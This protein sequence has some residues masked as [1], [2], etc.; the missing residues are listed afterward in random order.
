MLNQ[1]FTNNKGQEFQVLTNPDS[2]GI[3][4]VRYLATDTT[5]SA[6][7][8]SIKSKTLTNPILPATAGVGIR[9]KKPESDLEKKFFSRWATMLQR[10]YNTK[11][12][13]YQYYGARGVTVSEEFK[14][15]P[16]FWNWVKTQS[17]IHW[18]LDSDLSSIVH[19]EAKRYSKETLVFL[20]KPLNHKLVSLRKLLRHIKA[21]R[22]GETDKPPK[23]ISI[24][25]NKIQINIRRN[26]FNYSNSFAPDKL[27]SVLELL[28]QKNITE[29]VELSDSFELCPR[30]KELIECLKNS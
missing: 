11:D 8:A 12:T 15:F 3:C 22:S 26:G 5:T 20:P 23:G 17:N 28:K 7:V 10:C 25:D 16:N 9:G 1:V 2:N 24:Q 30:A 18:D 29:F 19:N 14:S 6:S 21:F 4:Q 27:D 13:D